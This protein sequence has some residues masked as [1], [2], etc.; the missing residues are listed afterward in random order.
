M[1]LLWLRLQKKRGYVNPYEND[2]TDK[3]YDLYNKINENEFKMNCDKELERILTE[4]KNG[5]EI[6]RNGTSK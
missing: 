6:I 4:Y 3:L 1:V 5:A 2:F